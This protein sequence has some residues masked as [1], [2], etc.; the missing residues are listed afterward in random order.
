MVAMGVGEHNMVYPGHFFI[1]KE[2]RQ[3]A[4][5]SL[6]GA[7]IDKGVFAARQLYIYG[8]P[9]TYIKEI[10]IKARGYGIKCGVL[11]GGGERD[12]DSGGGGAKL[13]ESLGVKLTGGKMEY[14]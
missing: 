7:A 13:A 2:L 8:I 11:R 4:G 3:G 6:G 1:G 5:G 9:L 14:G 10:N 12:L